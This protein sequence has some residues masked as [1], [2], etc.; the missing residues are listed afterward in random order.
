MASIRGTQLK[1]DVAALAWLG[2]EAS[3][4]VVRR[5]DP[6]LLRQ[7]EE[8]S[9]VD[10]LPHRIVVELVHRIR[11]VSGEEA[12]RG[13]S[14]AAVNGALRGSLFRPFLEGVVAVFGLSPLAACKILPKAYSA[15]LKDCGVLHLESASP[16]R[17][18]L[19]LEG[20]PPEARDRTWLV[21]VAGGFEVIFDACKVE[22]RFELVFDRPESAPR[23]VATWE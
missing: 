8:A 2:P 13:W 7:I 20:L 4:E 6:D 11:D 19:V 1:E 9:R 18:E 3:A 21:S 17:S 14:R 22:G 10:W 23:F 16:G 12:V 5:L 15:A